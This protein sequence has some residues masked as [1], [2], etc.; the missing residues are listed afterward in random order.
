MR[1]AGFTPSQWDQPGNKGICFSKFGLKRIFVVRLGIFSDVNALGSIRCSIDFGF[2]MRRMGM[3]TK[4]MAE[5]RER[6]RLGR[7][8]HT[9]NG[10]CEPHTVHMS[11]F[12]QEY[13]CRVLK[14]PAVGTYSGCFDCLQPCFGYLQCYNPFQTTKWIEQSL[15][16]HAQAIAVRTKTNVPEWEPDQWQAQIWSRS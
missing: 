12:D 13:D 2:R 6:E 11:C 1:N 14:H 4:S 8:L 3:Q 5:R 7:R 16:K 9:E 10:I 15:L